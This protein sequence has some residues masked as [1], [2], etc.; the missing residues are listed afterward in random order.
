MFV[1]CFRY[2]SRCQPSPS[3][4]H[5]NRMV[6]PVNTSLP[7]VDT[8]SASCMNRLS[9]LVFTTGQAGVNWTTTIMLLGT[10]LTKC[11]LGVG[12]PPRIYLVLWRR[13]F[14]CSRILFHY[15]NLKLLYMFKLRRSVS[16]VPKWRCGGCKERSGTRCDIFPI[17]FLVLS[18]FFHATCQYYNKIQEHTEKAHIMHG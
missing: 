15:S 7:S 12:W 9:H 1:S 11:F 17:C 2:L 14:V 5:L 6:L 10:V 18:F 8:A 3:A 16:R 13:S 4:D